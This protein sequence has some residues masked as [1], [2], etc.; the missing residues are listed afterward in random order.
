MKQNG[1]QI[2]K[3]NKKDTVGIGE[4]NTH[5]KKNYCTFFAKTF[6]YLQKK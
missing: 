1:N 5:K 6:G 3:V 4:N 2:K